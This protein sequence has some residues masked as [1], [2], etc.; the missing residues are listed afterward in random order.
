MESRSVRKRGG[1]FARQHKHQE[2]RVM[3]GKDAQPA[4]Y[5]S[6]LRNGNGAPE[7]M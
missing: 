5:L 7:P 4:R 6:I 1:K 3:T 2:T